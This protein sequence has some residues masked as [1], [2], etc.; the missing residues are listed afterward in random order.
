MADLLRLSSSLFLLFSLIHTVSPQCLPNTTAYQRESPP[1]L[2]QSR[3]LTLSLPLPLLTP[4]II[5]ASL[6]LT[7]PRWP[8][9][10]C[11]KYDYIPARITLPFR[12]FR[13]QLIQC[14]WALIEY[15]KLAEVPSSYY[16]STVACCDLP[17]DPPYYLL[18]QL[19]DSCAITSL[20]RVAHSSDRRSV[21]V[22]PLY[23]WLL[24]HQ[25]TMIICPP[26]SGHSSLYLFP[27]LLDSSWA[28]CT[29]RSF[30]NIEFVVFAWVRIH[31]NASF[32]PL[33]SFSFISLIGS[34]PLFLRAKRL[35]SGQRIGPSP[36][37]ESR[38]SELISKARRHEISIQ[39]VPPRGL[40]QLTVLIT[41]S[42]RKITQ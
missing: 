13:P 4:R 6:L 11:C 18:S 19:S 25:L 20:I 24:S 31:L 41:H 32:T 10:T 33:S 29:F 21:S 27:A 30:C 3:P 28:F 12:S 23:L 9:F 34:A 15:P 26:F 8:V 42:S 37:R 36:H 14:P 40:S 5:D 17:H 22:T 16:H 7:K 38:A 2:V 1:P 35:K 39:L